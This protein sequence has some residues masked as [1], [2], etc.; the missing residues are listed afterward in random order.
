MSLLHSARL[1][2]L[3]VHAYMKDILDRLPTLP[4]SRVTELL[5]QR[6]TPA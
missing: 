5:P 1:N 3:D 6:W 2:G 4:A